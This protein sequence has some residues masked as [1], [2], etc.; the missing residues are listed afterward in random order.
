ML[1]FFIR[2]ICL[3]TAS[4]ITTPALSQDISGWSDKTVCRLVETNGGA[5]YVKEA[6]SRGLDCK[7]G[8]STMTNASN[9]MDG[10]NG[11]HGSLRSEYARI[12]FGTQADRRTITLGPKD[13]G[14]PRYPPYKGK[15]SLNIKMPL[16]T[17]VLA[18]LDLEFI[19]YKNR[20]A[21][22]RDSF[23]PFDDLELCFKS[24]N[25]K[26][27]ELVMCIYHLR[28]SP[29]LPKMFK[30][31]KCDIRPDWNIGDKNVAKAGLIYYETNTSSYTYSEVS[32]TCGAK[33]G[34][35]YKRGE[36]I[37]YSGAVGK[38]AHVGFRFKVLGKEANPL[39]QK[40]KME[41]M[42]L[43][44]VQPSVFF[45]WKCFKPNAIFDSGVL[46]YPF[47]CDLL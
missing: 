47:D 27:N 41:N 35:I 13:G 31:E 5:A 20:N 23:R 24:I 25:N 9:I 11:A 15:N 22:K 39:T 1:N 18:P 4:L 17:E 19:G 14:L 3:L 43:H 45:K 10:L 29:L 42:Y 30:N 12:R 32:D 33:L 6:N 26:D 28:S 36:V 38:N 2:L 16:M 8:A 37:G 21:I 40:G 44:W 34:T 7:A 46:A